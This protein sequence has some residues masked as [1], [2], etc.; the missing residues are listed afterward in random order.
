MKSEL[1]FVYRF[2]LCRI[3]ISNGIFKHF[4]VMVMIKT[5]KNKELRKGQIIQMK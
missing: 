4:K 5:Y 3:A 1:K 2:G